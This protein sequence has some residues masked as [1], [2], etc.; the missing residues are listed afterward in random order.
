MYVNLNKNTLPKYVIISLENIK[1]LFGF[2]DWSDYSS[3]L[4]TVLSFD[5]NADGTSSGA[6]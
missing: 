2:F 5:P 3:S 1:A 4:T 6:T